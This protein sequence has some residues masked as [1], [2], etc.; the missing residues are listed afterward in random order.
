MENI[1]G[2]KIQYPEV[3]WLFSSRAQKVSAASN[4]SVVVLVRHTVI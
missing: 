4:W 1:R 2:E 3:I